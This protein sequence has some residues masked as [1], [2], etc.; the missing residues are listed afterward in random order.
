VKP[1]LIRD[2]GIWVCA[3]ALFRGRTMLIGKWPRGHGYTP[4]EAYDDWRAQLQ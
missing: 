3:V 2:M 1:T 4:R